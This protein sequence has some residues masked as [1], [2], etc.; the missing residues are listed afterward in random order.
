MTDQTKLFITKG[1]LLAIKQR[2]VD[3]LADDATERE[4]YLVGEYEFGN[5][6][7][8]LINSGRK[9]P[10]SFSGFGD[11]TMDVIEAAVTRLAKMSASARDRHDDQSAWSV[12][13]E[14][15][16]HAIADEFKADEKRNKTADTTPEVEV[17]R[18]SAAAERVARAMATAGDGGKVGPDAQTEPAPTLQPPAPAP[19]PPAVVE[20]SPRRVVE[21]IDR[22][23]EP[24]VA[25]LTQE[26]ERALATPPQPDVVVTGKLE[27][28]A[29]TS[30]YEN[31]DKRLSEAWKQPP[32]SRPKKRKKERRHADLV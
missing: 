10:M 30:P 32:P 19:A 6:V 20:D 7:R 18:P 14:R 11:A 21:I 12:F 15:V 9:R 31:Y 4:R 28:I 29:A 16:F 23:D 5:R 13:E 2:C 22:R 25:N 26:L 3:K 24:A 1:A 27:T 17:Q 8:E